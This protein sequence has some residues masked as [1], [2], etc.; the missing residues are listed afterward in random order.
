M[1]DNNALHDLL[2]RGAPQPPRLL[3]PDRVLAAARRRVAVRH[4][5]VAVAA[6]TAL[7][8]LTPAVAARLDMPQA[9]APAGQVEEVPLVVSALDELVELDE[10]QSYFTAH[11]DAATPGRAARVHLREEYPRYEVFLSET[12]DDRI[13][14]ASVWV[15]SGGANGCFPREDLLGEGVI[16]ATITPDEVYRLEVVLPDGYDTAS[17]GSTTVA[18]ENN[19]AVMAFEDR[20]AGELV[21]S[22]P[23]RPTVS[24]DITEAYGPLADSGS[25]Q[26]LSR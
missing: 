25:A 23:G 20:P 13:C 5:T 4:T 24:F 12:T 11:P 7:I 22:G 15:R 8:V 16:L 3:D 1:S 21:A 17:T 6:A 26:R 18:V 9:L 2:H 14:L 19:V 10:V